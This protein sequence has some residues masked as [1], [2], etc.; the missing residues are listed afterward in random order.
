MKKILRFLPLI[1]LAGLIAMFFLGLKQDPRK[2]PSNLIGKTIPSFNLADL[3]QPNQMISPHQFQGQVWLLNVWASWCQACRHEHDLLNAIAGS[4]TITLVG[5]NY[6][7]HDTAAK[8]W[9]VDMGGNPYQKI[10]IDP[11]GITGIDLGIYGVPE[12]F[13]IDKTG[14]IAYRYTGALT[15]QDYQQTLLPIIE[16]LKNE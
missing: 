6:K 4:K 2:L 10:A 8:Q 12:T 7:D 5:L 13:I 16:K 3:H 14:K 11:N 1:L 15:P 9:L